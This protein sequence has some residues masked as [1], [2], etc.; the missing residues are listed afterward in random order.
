MNCY[1][2]TY[3]NIIINIDIICLILNFN[4]AIFISKVY[5]IQYIYKFC[6]SY[7]AWLKNFFYFNKDNKIP[8]NFFLHCFLNFNSYY[9]L[10]HSFYWIEI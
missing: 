9:K 1:K 7:S 5:Q 10:S 2:I 4:V 8:D 6:I 3:A